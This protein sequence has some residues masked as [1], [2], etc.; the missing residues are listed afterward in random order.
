M[1]STDFVMLMRNLLEYSFPDVID[2]TFYTVGDDAIINILPNAEYLKAIS[3]SGDEIFIDSDGTIAQLL[4]NEVGTYVVSMTIAGTESRYSIYS[5]AHPGE[6][7]P[8]VTEA[9]LSVSGEREYNSIDGEFDATTVLFICLAILF[10]A[11]WG[12][13]CYEKYQLR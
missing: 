2:E 3:P 4:L 11:D 1:L 10:V 9:E 8:A 13:Y 12:V 7:D 5:G 6:S